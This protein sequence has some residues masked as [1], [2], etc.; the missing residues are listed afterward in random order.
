VHAHRGRLS[1]AV[2]RTLL[3]ERIVASRLTRVAHPLS[4]MAA[5]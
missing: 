3:R 2:F 5:R 1:A 4:A